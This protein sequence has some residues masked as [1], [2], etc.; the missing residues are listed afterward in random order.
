MEGLGLDE[1]LAAAREGAVEPAFNGIA[2]ALAEVRARASPE[3]WVR[4][5]QEARAHPLREFVHQD[6]FALRC[7]AKPRGYGPD[8]VALD[9]VLRAREMPNAGASAV[10]ALHRCL[11]QGETARALVFRRDRVAQDIAAAAASS[12]QP[13]RIFAAPSG[14]LREW[15]RVGDAARKVGELVAFD[16]DPENLATARR[17]Y[18]HLPISSHTG[19]VHQLIRREHAFRDMDV[20]YCCG[21]L[22]TL[23][24][25]AAMG[26]AR[27]LFEMVRRGGTLILT[28]F[29]PRLREAAYLE[30]FLDWRMAYRS[31]S[32][33]FAVVQR[34]MQEAASQWTYGESPESTLG[35]LVVR[36]R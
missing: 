8:G 33:F 5:I 16:T 15:D 32:D 26:L 22:E 18:P 1:A 31:Q 3:E 17:D 21:L 14:H 30:T 20:V 28:H 27:A 36:R 25:A 13:L 6:P 4:A 29:L 7:Y 34:V 9:Y 23:P 11:T 2:S 19:S 10:A 12:A 24:T 35:V